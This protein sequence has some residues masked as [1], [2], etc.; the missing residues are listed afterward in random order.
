MNKV[1]DAIISDLNEI[2]ERMIFK[3]PSIDDFKK[4]IDPSCN[5]GRIKN[6]STINGRYVFRSILF[7]DDLKIRKIIQN[8]INVNPDMKNNISEKTV[9]DNLIILFDTIKSENRKITTKDIQN[10]CDELLKSLTSTQ[11]TVLHKIYGVDIK[12]ESPI[13]V[14]IFTFYSISK[15]KKFVDFIV[16]KDGKEQRGIK[17]LKDEFE[18]HDVWVSVSFQMRADYHKAKEQAEKY[19]SYLENILRFFLYPKNSSYDIG[20]FDFKK[21]NVEEI[22]LFSEEGYSYEL[23]RTS[24]SMGGKILDDLF[25]KNNQYLS[26]LIEL[27]SKEK[28]SEMEDRILRFTYLGG[29]AISELDHSMGFLKCMMAIEALLQV[30]KEEISNQISENVSFILYGNYKE[31]VTENR[32]EMYNIMKKLYSKRSELAHGSKVELPI[33][34]Y[35][36]M[37]QIIQYLIR[38]FLDTEIYCEMKEI[39]ELEKYIQKLKFTVS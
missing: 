23:K 27:I 4:M 15:H 10:K 22:Y 5:G 18:K 33:E 31:T 16:I 34:D 38:I 13:S 6:Y 32:I 19:F 20:I 2:L 35:N 14:G 11:F 21:S 24:G 36:T 7:E 39:D 3:D 37:M 30:N 28:R 1:N 12:S 9:Y 26:K 17:S 8:I 29:M 25:N